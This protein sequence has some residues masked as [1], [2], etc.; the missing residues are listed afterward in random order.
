MSEVRKDDQPNEVTPPERKNPDERN[1]Q[2][3]PQKVQ[4]ETERDV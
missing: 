4:R 2:D 3:D 1:R